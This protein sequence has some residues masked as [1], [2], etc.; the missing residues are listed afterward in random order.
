M[1]EAHGD[2]KEAHGEGSA[3]ER[4]LEPVGAADEDRDGE[5]GDVDDRAR[6]DGELKMEVHEEENAVE[7]EVEPI[8][9][10]DDHHENQQGGELEK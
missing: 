8:R 6:V 3:E 2:G 4:E 9:A 7:R 1:L 5:Q 10:K